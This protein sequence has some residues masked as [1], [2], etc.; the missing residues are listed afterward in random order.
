MKTCVNCGELI[1]DNADDCFKCHYNYKYRRVI[2]PQE[3][4][5]KREQEERR[6]QEE[7]ERRKKIEQERVEQLAKNGGYE[8]KIEVVRD[9]DDSAR[10]IQA[11]LT[12]YASDGWRLHTMFSNEIGREWLRP[13]TPAYPTRTVSTYNQIVMVFERMIKPQQN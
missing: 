7:S 3:I 8:Y 1:G 4:R 9:Q 10:E 2:S 13:D 11:L 5:Q 12:R 6:R